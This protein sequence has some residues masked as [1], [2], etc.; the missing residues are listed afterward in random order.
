MG[1]AISAGRGKGLL[2]MK[3]CTQWGPNAQMQYI[4]VML[5]SHFIDEL[6]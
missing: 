2:R 6:L 4:P 5:K 1:L 3:R